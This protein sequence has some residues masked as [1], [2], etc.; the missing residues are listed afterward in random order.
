M[1][2][3]KAIATISPVRNSFSCASVIGKKDFLFVWQDGRMV[4]TVL[5]S[6]GSLDL[7]VRCAKRAYL[8]R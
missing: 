1:T 2:I 5:W 6:S 7:Y 3:A 8:F 4:G